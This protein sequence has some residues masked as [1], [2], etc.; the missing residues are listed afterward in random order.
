MP[1]QPSWGVSLKLSLS[2][3]VI[4]ALNSLDVHS[5][6]AQDLHPQGIRS[7]QNSHAERPKNRI[8]ALR[9]L[10]QS[11]QL[12]LAYRAVFGS[13]PP[14][15]ELENNG[16]L[17]YRAGRVYWTGVGPVLIAPAYHS[18]AWLTERGTLGVFFLREREGAFKLERAFFNSV[19]G[20][21]MGNPPDWKLSMAFGDFPLIIAI[22]LNTIGGIGCGKTSLYKL[23]YNVVSWLHTFSSE[24]D[25]SANERDPSQIV[26]LIG[27]MTNIK[28]NGTFD[29]YY[30]GTKRFVHRYVPLFDGY[31]FAP[32]SSRELVPS[33]G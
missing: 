15:K 12:R 27:T 18:N 23:E 25:N 7:V 2:A 22:T 30:T 29:V 9:D 33:C 24:Y 6:F 26:R 31:D 16:L 17:T 3:V 1:D 4:V 19:Q 11:T 14:N 10:P 20:S 13:R 28:S 21:F 32:N 5:A 8:A